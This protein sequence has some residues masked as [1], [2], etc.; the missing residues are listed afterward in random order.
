MKVA[1][2][3]IATPSNGGI[4]GPTMG[5]GPGASPLGDLAMAPAKTE[6]N[7]DREEKKSKQVR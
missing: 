3:E 1:A 7:S 6:S 5:S 4:H 2:E